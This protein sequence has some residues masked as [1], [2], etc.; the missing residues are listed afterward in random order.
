MTV[1]QEPSGRTE[2][3]GPERIYRPYRS[4]KDAELE[5][6]KAHVWRRLFDLHEDGVTK[7]MPPLRFILSMPPSC[8]RV[9]PRVS[10]HHR[11]YG[12]HAM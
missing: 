2:E 4:G 1:F 10:H 12:L 3:R 5:L 7:R 6:D 11:Y 9:S 8:S